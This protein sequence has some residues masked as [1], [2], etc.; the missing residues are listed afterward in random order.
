MFFTF[1]PE[2]FLNVIKLRIESLKQTIYADLLSYCKKKLEKQVGT[3]STVVTSKNIRV[4]RL[5]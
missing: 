5:S 1:M 3:K 2:E 4:I